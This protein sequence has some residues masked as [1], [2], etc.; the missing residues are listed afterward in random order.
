VI[1]ALPGIPGKKSQ[2]RNVDE[3]WSLHQKTE[4]D[5]DKWSVAY[6]ALGVTRHQS[7]QVTSTN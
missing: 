1:T 7:S 6:D 3:K 4:L 5:G 2:E